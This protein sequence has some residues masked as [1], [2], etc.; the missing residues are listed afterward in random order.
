MYPIIVQVGPVTIY[1]FGLMM[2]VAFLASGLIVGKEFAR[3][4]L[5][6]NLASPLVFWA[7]V[8]GLVGA[9]LWVIM[10]DFAGFLDAPLSFLLS[11][12]GF[13]WYGGL[14]GGIIAMS[15]FIR[16]HG[17]PWLVTTDCVAASVPLGH[18][19]GRIGCQLAGDGDWGTETTL[20]WGMAYRNAI[21]GWDYPP[22]VRV[23]PTPLY[24]A[25]MY[26]AIFAVLWS[27]RRRLTSD[28]AMLGAYLVLAGA[29]RFVVDFVR[30]EPRIVFELT[31]AQLASVGIVLAG[32]AFLGRGRLGHAD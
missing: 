3:K 15:A 26:A 24:E 19:V 27:M 29:A 16:R 2:A 13:V 21:I 7:A 14:A 1:S 25:A 11:G 10:D 8:G 20:P 6:V 9:R 17:L 23:H 28:G 31:A 12:A 4:G 30:T 32:L 22:D 5:D 18:A